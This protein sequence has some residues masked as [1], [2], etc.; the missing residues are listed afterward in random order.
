MASPTTLADLLRSGYKPP[1]ESALGDPIVEHF[2]ALPQQLATNQA[3]LDSAIGSWNKTDFATGQPNPNYRPEAI[4]ELTQ[5]MPNMAGM[6][7]YHGTPHNI[8][9]KFDLNKVGTGEGAQHFGHGIY[10]AES[11]AI[12]SEYK[13]SDA[14]KLL[15]NGLE[16]ESPVAKQIARYGSPQE[17]IKSMDK[18][19]AKKT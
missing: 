8:Q 4:Q 14:V 7:A 10:F 16:T 1:T 19:V 11:P 13:G 5:L 9:G 17:Y 2:R 12:A 15:A 3:A 18:V 6:I